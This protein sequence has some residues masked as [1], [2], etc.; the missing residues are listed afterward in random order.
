M[1]PTRFRSK[2]YLGAA[3]SEP[4][5][6][7]DRRSVRRADPAVA[8]CNQY[9]LTFDNVSAAIY[10]GRLQRLDLAGK[11]LILSADAGVSENG[12]LRAYFHKKISQAVTRIFSTSS[13]L[14]QN[15]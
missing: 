10:G 5:I 13:S 8:P 11:V 15:W 4:T 9:R 6:P 3:P 7:A 14:L 2:D 12:H 1:I